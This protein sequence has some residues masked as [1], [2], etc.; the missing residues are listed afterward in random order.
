MTRI[1]LAPESK[2]MIAR[3]AASDKRVCL[4]Q[5]RTWLAILLSKLAQY[6][7]ASALESNRQGAIRLDGAVYD[8]VLMEEGLDVTLKA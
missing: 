2:D 6:D 7:M 8:K 4:A 5:K 1:E 3:L